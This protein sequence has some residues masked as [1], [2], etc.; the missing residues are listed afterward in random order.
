MCGQH[1]AC[2]QGFAQAQGCR[3]S[4]MWGD[5]E[6]RGRPVLKRTERMLERE[7]LWPLPLSAV[8]PHPGLG[9]GS[10]QDPAQSEGQGEVTAPLITAAGGNMAAGS[11]PLTPSLPRPGPDAAF[12]HPLTLRGLPG[13]LLQPR[14]IAKMQGLG[15]D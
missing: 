3:A 2:V 10:D 7:C 6:E 12:F 9:P 1:V 13:C 5:G 11:R 14:L 15:W 8:P 4:W